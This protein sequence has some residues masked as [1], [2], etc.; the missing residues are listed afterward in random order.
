MCA[1]RGRQQPGLADSPNWRVI[2]VLVAHGNVRS[3][4]VSRGG[5]D[6][7]VFPRWTPL[8]TR[9]S[10]PNASSTR[11]RVR[12]RWMGD[13]R[14]F[15]TPPG[16]SKQL[17]GFVALRASVSRAAATCCGRVVDVGV[18]GVCVCLCMHAP[19][20][21]DAQ[22][23]YI[24]CIFNP[25]RWGVCDAHANNICFKACEFYFCKYKIGMLIVACI[26]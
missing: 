16:T 7:V 25:M 21:H 10:A 26:Q 24:V 12:W 15:N 3:M 19:A 2:P 18:A 14:V 22:E 1:W 6:H 17:I 9:P 13:Q 20:Q 23:M 11:S 8:S 4:R 5:I